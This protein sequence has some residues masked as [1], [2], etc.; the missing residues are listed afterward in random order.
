MSASADDPIAALW[1]EIRPN[2]VRLAEGLLRDA[3]TVAADL[4]DGEAWG[5]VRAASHRLAGTLGSFG[6]RA[7]GDAAV[8]LE[9]VTGGVETPDQEL[10]DR[11][12][13]LADAIVTALHA[14]D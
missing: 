8:A 11:T 7:A 2:Q 4:D 1:L 6:Q 13:S 12:V 14:D 3:R 5:Q 10:A 9:E